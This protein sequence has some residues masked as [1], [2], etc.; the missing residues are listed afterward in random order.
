MSNGVTDLES[1]KN[2]S[3]KLLLKMKQRGRLPMLNLSGYA[4]QRLSELTGEPIESYQ[5]PCPFQMTLS[6]EDERRAKRLAV[7]YSSFSD[8][9]LARLDRDS[10][11]IL[12]VKWD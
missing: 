4:K 11:P 5:E 8:E 10:I 12:G 7:I 2:V 6:K 9:E 1:L 3:S